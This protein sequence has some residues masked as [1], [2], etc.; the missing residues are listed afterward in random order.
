M[1][2]NREIKRIAREN[3]NGHY[4]NFVPAQ[5]IVSLL[6]SLVLLPF[7]LLLPG[8]MSLLQSLI[9]LLAYIIVFLL[10]VVLSAGY[11]FLHLCVARQKAYRFADLFRCFRE[12]PDSY[13]LGTLLLL[14]YLL[15]FILAAALV[16]GL[17][18]VF[19]SQTEN[20]LLIVLGVIV[21]IVI[22]I[23]MIMFSLYYAM[24]LPILVDDPNQSVRAALKESRRI[25]TGRRKQ[26]FLL[27]LSFIGWYLLG[28]LS[29]AIGFLWIYPYILQSFVVF[30]QDASGQSSFAQP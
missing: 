10:S 18:I 22:L 19:G 23:F 13:L 11:L 17:S 29:L 7:S 28:L 5:L 4:M 30:Y 8:T 9:F 20:P 26:L 2:P 16:L 1:T 15:P 27:Y 3:L 6:P 12:R 25:M 21:Y 14:L 24:Y